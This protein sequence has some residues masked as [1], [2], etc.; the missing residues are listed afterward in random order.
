M[1]DE[2]RKGCVAYLEDGLHECGRGG[3]E[4]RVGHATGRGDDLPTAAVHRLVGDGG[5]D[6]LE[7]DVADGLVAQRALQRGNI[8]KRG[9]G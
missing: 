3:E 8:E 5:V 6:D 2:S 7:L 9:N 1:C 4:S